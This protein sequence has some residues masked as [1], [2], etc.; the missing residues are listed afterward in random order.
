MNKEK[1]ILTAIT[2]L[3]I[4]TWITFD[5]FLTKPSTPVPPNL[6]EA[7]EPINPSFDQEAL[8]Q[9]DSKVDSSLAVISKTSTSSA[10][11]QKKP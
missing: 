10:K 6:K 5:V 7:L 11:V 1:V 9:I 4:M 3:A 8:K 2:F